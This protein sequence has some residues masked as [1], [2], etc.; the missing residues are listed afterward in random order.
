M[1]CIGIEPV[2]SRTQS[3][4]HTTRPASHFLVS[5]TINRLINLFLKN[6][7]HIETFHPKAEKNR[8]ENDKKFKHYFLS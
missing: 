3:E 8:I 5:S 1:A 2:T 4:N 6:S 7:F